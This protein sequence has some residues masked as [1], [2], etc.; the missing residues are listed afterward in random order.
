MRNADSPNREDA[1]RNGVIKYMSSR[2]GGKYRQIGERYIYERHPRAKRPRR[3][4][5]LPRFG[6]SLATAGK[7]FAVLFPQPIVIE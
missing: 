3:R 4:G 5:A 7:G 6:T 2:P 1:P